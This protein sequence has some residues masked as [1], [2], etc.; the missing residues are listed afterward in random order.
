MSSSVEPAPVSD[1][2]VNMAELI[3]INGW[4]SRDKLESI[5]NDLIQKNRQS[6]FTDV[7]AIGRYLVENRLLT[8]EQ[9][10]IL[11]NLVQQQ[12]NFPD[13]QLLKHLGAGGMGTVF[14]AKH[15][16]SGR[17]IA[18]KTM[19]ARL[20]E[21]QDFVGRFHRESKVLTG[22]HHQY[23]A[24]IY[25]SGESGNACY[26]AMEYVEG[27][28]LA[29]LL[30]QHKVL[31]E[32]YVLTI[33]KQVAEGLAYVYEKAELVHR[34]IKPE[35]ILIARDP[36]I[37]EDFSAEDQAKL[38]DFGLVKPASDDQHLTQ[39]GMTIGTPLYMSPEQIRGESIDCRSDIYGLGATMYHLLTGQ[40]PFAGTSPGAIMS[41]HLTQPVP[42]PGMR[43]PG[44]NPKTR[45]LII[46]SMAKKRDDRFLTFAAF[47]KAIDAALGNF[48]EKSNSS[49]KLLR[50][51]LVIKSPIRK[52]PSPTVNTEENEI[53]ADPN[54]SPSRGN[55][56]VDHA[57]ERILNKFKQQKDSVSES[58]ISNNGSNA[59]VTKALSPTNH[60]NKKPSPI[61]TQMNRKIVIPTDTL[62]KRDTTKSAVY[63]EDPT[64]S[65]GTGLIPW[66][67]LIIALVVLGVWFL[68]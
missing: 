6:L 52:A 37:N 67:A 11:D 4:A 36:S 30:K 29:S 5:R 20:K 48:I 53:E 18:I 45:E 15:G 46:M 28:S 59:V 27:P 57:T 2:F 44:L 26:M 38:I 31:P 22:L 47:I 54:T 64:V 41:A 24:D 1:H 17:T 63:D 35:N 66:I 12:K 68:L 61:T 21:D 33:G 16:D 10:T 19:M 34:D 14:L 60:V 13:Y 3:V 25:E 62:R 42:D 8:S 56:T 9:M 32:S 50:K 58:S 40:T 65:A 49:P 39:T 55:K 43:V 51:P 7:R 23:I